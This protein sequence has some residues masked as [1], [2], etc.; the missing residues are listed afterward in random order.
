MLNVIPP[1][2]KGLPTLQPTHRRREDLEADD[3]VRRHSINAVFLDTAGIPAVAR[4]T[5]V[6]APPRVGRE[7]RA[8]P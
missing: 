3:A 1:Q 5:G 6:D 8:F 7:G 4:K 2:A